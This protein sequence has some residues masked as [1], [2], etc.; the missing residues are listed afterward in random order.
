MKKA[1]LIS[2]LVIGGIGA[3]FFARR[4][5]EQIMER[6]RDARGADILVCPSPQ[7]CD[8]RGTDTLSSASSQ[9]GVSASVSPE[10][11]REQVVKERKRVLSDEAKSILS[12]ETPYPTRAS[13]IQGL[14][15]N[16]PADGV[17]AF[18]D[19]LNSPLADHSTIRPIVLNSI[20][21]ELL[22][23]LMRQ[24]ELP[25]GLGQQVIDMFNDPSSDY[26][27]R[28]YCLQ[29]MQ[30]L[31]ERVS[32]ESRAHGA[33]SAPPTSNL[34][35]STSRFQPSTRPIIEAMMGALDE[36]DQDLAGTALLGLSRLSERNEGFDHEEILAKAVEMAGDSKASARCRLT[37]MRIAA[38]DR[39]AEIL[40]AARELAV[41][42]QTV[43]LRG[44]AITTL[45]DFGVQQDRSLLEKL[46][47]SGSRQIMAAAKAALAKVEGRE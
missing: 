7:N 14:G 37:A 30:P 29:F 23:V 19:F 28:E 34:P 39:R 8:P 5:S 10:Q 21:N 42:G 27:W 15:R 1:L 44:A 16:L 46:S 36:R 43:L 18:R 47:V 11:G 25:A 35:L 33:E 32:A 26:M 17:A 4:S 45:G 9:T 38:A 40:P 13:L 41:N 20:K 6:S 3:L 24:V 22:E 2:I 31:Y 12:D